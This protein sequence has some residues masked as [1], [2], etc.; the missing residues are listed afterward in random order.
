MLFLKWNFIWKPYR[1]YLLAVFSHQNLLQIATSRWS[2]QHNLSPANLTVCFFFIMMG[3][4]QKKFSSNEVNVCQILLDQLLKLLA[5]VKSS[6]FHNHEIL[7]L[8]LSPDI[9]W[10]LTLLK[11]KKIC[12]LFSS[13]LLPVKSIIFVLH[14]Y[15][16]YYRQKKKKKKLLFFRKAEKHFS[17]MKSAGYIK[18]K[19]F[20]LFICLFFKLIC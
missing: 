16:W 11:S 8:I 15:C 4:V 9:T 19:Y 14:R 12:F 1:C 7:E 18:K 5:Y 6:L 13:Q 17:V 20:P 10:Q 3:I 2:R